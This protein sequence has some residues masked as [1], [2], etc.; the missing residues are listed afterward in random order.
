MISFL[1]YKFNFIGFFLFI[2]FIILSSFVHSQEID[3]KKFKEITQKLRCMTC[4]NQTIYES[5]TIFAQDIKAVIK[6]KLQK[7]ESV[8]QIEDFLVHRYGEYILF[9]PR[10]DRKNLILWILPFFIFCLSS[11]I[12]IFRLKTK[13]SK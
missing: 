2:I 9:K 5:E 6:E 12:L 13:N 10:F 7:G 3:E 4:Q 1:I 11:I 8:K